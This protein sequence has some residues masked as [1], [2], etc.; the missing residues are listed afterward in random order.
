MIL[1]GVIGLMLDVAMRLL[2]RLP[3]VRWRYVR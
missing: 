1:I 2:E 3:F